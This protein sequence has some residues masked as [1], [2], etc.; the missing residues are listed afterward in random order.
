MNIR[1]KQFLDDRD[2]WRV[3]DLL[4]DT[5]DR[6][7]T[8]F[9]W[10]VRRWDG[11][12]YY[13]TD[14][15]WVPEWSDTVRIWETDDGRIVGAV[16]PESRGTA[17]LQ[18]DPDFRMIEEEIIAW[19]EE[20]LWILTEA[21]ARQLHISV[22]EYDAER[23]DILRR[24]GYRELRRGA[25]M[26]KM[27][28]GSTELSSTSSVDGYDFVSPDPE[29]QQDCMR[30]ADLLN[31][32][33]KRDF[34][35]PEEYCTFARNAP[36]YSKGLDCIACASDGTFAAYVGVPFVR[37]NNYAVF[38]PVCTHPDHQRK[39]LARHLMLSA[40]EKLRT[41]GANEVL[42]GCSDNEAVNRTYKSVGFTEAYRESVWEKEL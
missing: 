35:T 28:L 2:F 41:M 19:A 39:G 30:I 5:Y 3:R 31:A 18:L 40:L 7:P 9:N 14:L 26:R 6:T 36:C 16:H 25:Y 27:D 17:H 42:V 24:R 10:E 20:N 8:G 29:N 38:E 15:T 13:N 21:G 4:I 33:F 1:S 32:A 37:E 12:R 23:I 34:H 22:F 11:W